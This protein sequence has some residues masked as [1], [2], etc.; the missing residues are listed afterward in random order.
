MGNL[1]CEIHPAIDLKIE[2]NTITAVIV[3]DDKNADAF[4][5]MVRAN[6]ANMVKGVHS[7][8]ERILEVNGIG[9][10][11]EVK[12]QTIVLSVGYSKPAEY[13]LPDGITAEVEKNQI[14][15]KGINRQQLGQIASE[16]RAI[17]PPE[18]YKGKGIK[19]L[20]ETI[21]RKAGKTAA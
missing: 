17:R 13:T 16:I 7:G 12:G 3:S 6:V 18:P 1:E 14:K 2:D 5:G 9:Y 19:Y 8:F 10:R 21:Q 15:L 11:V 4:H 20:E